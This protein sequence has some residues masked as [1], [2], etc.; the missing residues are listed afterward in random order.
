[1]KT[2]RV[3]TES[4]GGAKPGHIKNGTLGRRKREVWEA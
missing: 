3:K 2:G 4:A 1:M